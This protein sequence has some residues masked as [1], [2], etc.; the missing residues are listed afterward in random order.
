MPP[1]LLKHHTPGWVFAGALLLTAVAG[2]VNAVS[3]LSAFQAV[4]H[5]TGT[6]AA[7]SIEL[8]RGNYFIAARATGVVL[9]FILGAAISGFIV[10]KPTL[11]AHGRYGAALML[12]GVLLVGGW[13][14][15]LA[16]SE[17]GELLSAVA[18]GLQNALATSYSGAVVRT[19]H[20]TGVVTDLGM[21][22]G[23]WLAKE[24]IEWFRVQLHLV[25]MLGF[26]LGGALGVVGLPLFGPAVMLI[27]A[28]IVFVAGVVWTRRQSLQAQ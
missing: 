1:V 23:Q 9:C 19:T 2:C 20:L 11:D 14:G 13:V 16:D 18:C 27:P 15:M 10:R 8:G 6:V 17:W 5:M 24:P 22:L 7:V 12:E 3:L 21:T 25:L 28:G 26:T 4:T